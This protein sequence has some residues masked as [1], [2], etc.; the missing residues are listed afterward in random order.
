MTQEDLDDGR[1]IVLV[2]IA[3]VT[4]A[5]FV[6]LRIEQMIG[7]QRR[8][9]LLRRWFARAVLAPD[10]GRLRTSTAPYR[11]AADPRVTLRSQMREGGNWG[12]AASG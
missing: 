4:P 8:Q 12:A 7:G 3:P 10:E 9:G 1:L 11:G 6:V 2:G 5:E